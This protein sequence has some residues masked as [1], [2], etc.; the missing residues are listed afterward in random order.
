MLICRAGL[1]SYEIA[2]DLT[3]YLKDED[4]FVPWRA[5]LDAMNFIRGML[6]TSDIYGKLQVCLYVCERLIDWLIH[7]IAFSAAKAM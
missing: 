6:A 4:N 5:F 1:L 2:F 7:Y 3:S